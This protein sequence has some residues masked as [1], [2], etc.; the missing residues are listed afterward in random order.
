MTRE[1]IIQAVQVR[2]DELSPFDDIEE[3]PAINYIDKLLDASTDTVFRVLPYYK[4]P[5][6]DQS[7][8]R[9]TKG[10]MP[11]EWYL[12]MPDSFIKF[13]ECKFK[14]WSRVVKKLADANSENLQGSIYTMG[15]PSKPV[16]VLR[17]AGSN[18]RLHFFSNKGGSSNS[19][20]TLLI[21]VSKKPE[22][23]PDELVDAIAWQCAS[24]VLISLGKNDAAKVAQE[25]VLTH[26][27]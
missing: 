15:T 25:K 26:G 10:D 4:L 19:I 11:G 14:N 24:D 23:C 1:E 27:I 12:D 22:N 21:V 2:L 8:S 18:Q 16:V 3:V 20:K 5:L 7:M 17:R 6:S 13:G 9:L